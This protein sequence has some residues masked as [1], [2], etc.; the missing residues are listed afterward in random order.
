MLLEA[1][2]CVAKCACGNVPSY[3]LYGAAENLIPFPPQV[4]RRHFDLAVANFCIVVHGV[5]GSLLSTLA[6]SPF[7]VALLLGPDGDELGALA[8]KSLSNSRCEASRIICRSAG[9]L[10]A[11]QRTNIPIST[12]F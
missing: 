1:A 2:K 3:N 5:A 6:H 7:W 8:G 4:C 10:T 11:C 9:R 12:R